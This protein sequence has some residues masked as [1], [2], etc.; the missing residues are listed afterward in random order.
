MQSRELFPSNYH[1]NIYVVPQTV[2][3]MIFEF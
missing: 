2:Q 3:S 1:A